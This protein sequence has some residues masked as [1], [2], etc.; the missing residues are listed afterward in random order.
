MI[1]TH[2]RFPT[3][4]RWTVLEDRDFEPKVYKSPV[5]KREEVIRK[6]TKSESFPSTDIATY[7]NE[8]RE[9]G[10]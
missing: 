6:N 8:G 9:G 1:L 3:R 4:K 2:T 7:W 5:E 10:E